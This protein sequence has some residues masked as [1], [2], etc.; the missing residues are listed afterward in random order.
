MREQIFTRIYTDNLWG[1]CQ[2][3]SGTGS[4]LV[5]TRDMIN[6]IPFIIKK[7]N[8]KTIF[9]AGCGDWNWF[10]EISFDVKYTGADIV[11]P[12]V[13]ELNKKYQKPNVNFVHMDVVATKFGYHDLVIARDM[14]FHLSYE[15]LFQFLLNFEAS[16]SKFLLTTHSGDFLNAD[17]VTGD[18]RHLNLFAPPLNFPTPIYMIDDNQ[19]TRKVCLFT[20]EQL[21]LQT[22]RVATMLNNNQTAP[23]IFVQIASY[24][25]VE[26]QHTVKDLFEKATHPER[27]FVG[28][29]WQFV[30]GEDDICFEVP[31]PRPD[32]VRVHEE[33]ALTGKGACWARSL[34]QK[35]WR[36]EEFTLQIDSHMRFEQGWDELLLGMWR[37]CEDEKAVLTCY[38]PSYTPPDELERKWV[39]GMAARPFDEHGILLLNGKPAFAVDKGLPKKPING[40][41]VSANMLFGP[42]SIISDVPYDP[43]LY[44]F[45]EEITLAVRL[46]T[47][48]YN[49]FHPNALVIYHDWVRNRRPTHFGDHKDW[50]DIDMRSFARV[51]HMLRT[52]ISC[53]A[54]ITQGLDQFGL[55]NVRSLTEYE[56]H[57]G[58]DFTRKTIAT[59][60]LEGV[61]KRYEP[62]NANRVSCAASTPPPGVLVIE[63]FISPSMCKMLRDYADSRVGAK[64]G[65]VDPASGKGVDSPGRVTDR[66]NID[67]KPG[68]IL[69]LFNIIYARAMESF[70]KVN[71][72]WYERPQILRYSPG[73]KY[74]RHAD[75]DHW[76]AEAESWVRIHDRDFSVLLYL[77]DDY[78]GGELEF[79][80]FN[81]KV[82]PKAG[83]V[84]GF[85]S[86]H[87]Y[88]HAAL[89]T[90]SGMRYVIVSWGAVL[91]T[92]R[93]HEKAPYASVLLRI[94]GAS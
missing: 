70:F 16:G 48:G 87:R 89:P 41:F 30:K 55:G 19:G 80:H 66:V 67:G 33:D 57:S 13:S 65:V 11:A 63:N 39:F 85:P 12:L 58:V 25:D 36:G 9:D 94:K 21:M 45:G 78:E 20:R 17:I 6:A 56:A 54:S 32:Q 92:Q 43:N 3:R 47:H 8:I 93:V 28:I 14:L 60:A 59:H 49:I 83:M 46:W 5:S 82:K 38:P 15:D 81:Y 72:E 4:E 90:L 79:V 29:C 91:G 7:C 77:N 50:R 51:R 62:V 26:C 74:D 86:D 88:L 42:A 40:V 71:F 23:A 44:F 73:G 61:F 34:V 76:V 52:E 31:Y 68:E 84:V 18:W 35:L 53:D 37:D 10:K 22:R 27:V 24:R 69:S 75:A 64:L 2:T 1:S